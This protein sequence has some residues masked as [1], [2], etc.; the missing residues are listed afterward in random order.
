MSTEK[1]I[2]SFLLII[3]ILVFLFSKSSAFTPDSNSTFILILSILLVS[4]KIPDISSLLTKPAT[5]LS[6][7]IAVFLISRCGVDCSCSEEL[8]ESEEPSPPW[9]LSSCEL[10]P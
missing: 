1:I 6:L 7:R 9:E 4:H 5:F 10:S 3:L 2:L 8:P